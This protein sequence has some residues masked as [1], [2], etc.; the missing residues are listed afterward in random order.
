M[1]AGGLPKRILK[2][3]E[4]L[5]AEPYAVHHHHHKTNPAPKKERNATLLTKASVP[6]INAVPHAENLRYFDV[7]IDGPGSSPYE[8]SLSFSLDQIH[9]SLAGVNH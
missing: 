1:A 5:M 9:T 8:G 4:R 6:G 7:T 3:T 2:E